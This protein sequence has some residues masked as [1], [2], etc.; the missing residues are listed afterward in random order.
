MI[1]HKLLRSLKSVDRFQ[2]FE[3]CQHKG[4]F[5]FTFVEERGVSAP[6]SNTLF[7]V[8][9]VNAKICRTVLLSMLI[10]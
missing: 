7:Y 1:R 4:S 6:S 10:N 3:E 5:E 8:E 2:C 9:I